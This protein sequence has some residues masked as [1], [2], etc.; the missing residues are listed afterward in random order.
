MIALTRAV[1]PAITDCEL[2]YIERQ[3]IDIGLAKAQ[4]DAYVQCLA[5][6][7]CDIVHL[8]PLP[9]MADAVFVEDTA[10]VLDEVAVMTRPGAA[11]RRPEVDSVAAVL[12]AYRETCYIEAPATIDGGDVLVIGRRVFVGRSRRS[13]GPAVEQL[14]SV[15]R[16]FGYS[17][18]PVAMDGCLHLKSAV[19]AVGQGAVL[20]NRSWVDAEPFRGLELIDVAAGEPMGA[21]ALVVGAALVYAAQFPRTLERLQRAGIEVHVVAMTE[22]AKAEGAVTCCSILLNDQVETNA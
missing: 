18:E 11:S 15:L 6:L 19:T 8:P 22:L 12:K 7:G 3:P 4:H 5:Q 10:V 2:T 14:R 20:I 21:N 1:S 16:D 13:S 9:D 17:V